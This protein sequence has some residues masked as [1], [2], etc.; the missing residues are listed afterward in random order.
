MNPTRINT[1]AEVNLEYI[2]GFDACLLG[3]ATRGDLVVP[4]YSWAR[5]CRWGGVERLQGLFLHSVYPAPLVLMPVNRP[6]FWTQVQKGTIKVWDQLHDAI[7]GT[8][9]RQ[10]GKETAVYSYPR[11]IRALERLIEGSKGV[12]TTEFFETQ[13]D[14][15]LGPGTPWVLHPVQ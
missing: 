15:W 7:I 4:C 6:Y 2:P 12:T 8:G 1:A 13:L 11:V 5:G 3:Y 9:R 10:L 14:V